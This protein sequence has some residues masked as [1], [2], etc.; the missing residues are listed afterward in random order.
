ME[1]TRTVRPETRERWERALA[2]ALA[3]G[4][5]ILEVG[6]AAGA[7][8]VESQSRPGV[9]FLVDAAGATCTCE[10]AAGGDGVCA[11][12][13]LARFVAGTLALPTETCPAC[14]GEGVEGV[15]WTLAPDLV[16]CSGCNGAGQIE[17]TVAAFLAS[18]PTTAEVRRGTRERAAT[19]A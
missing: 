9:V 3:A 11:H 13:A 7:W 16:T 12:R 5:D 2:R 18:I 1:A 4:I 6:G 15:G 14:R 10:A 8:A 19:A 17:Q